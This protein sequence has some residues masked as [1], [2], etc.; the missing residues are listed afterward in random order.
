MR[1]KIMLAA[2][3][4]AAIAAFA[5]APALDHQRKRRRYKMPVPPRLWISTD[6]QGNTYPLG[7]PSPTMPQKLSRLKLSRRVSCVTRH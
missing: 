6:N 5:F 3:V 4:A 1:K 7:G 2:A